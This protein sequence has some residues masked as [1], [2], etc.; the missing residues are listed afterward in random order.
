[1]DLCCVTWP[2][3]NGGLRQEIQCQSGD[4][5]CKSFGGDDG[6]DWYVVEV[7]YDTSTDQMEAYI[8][9]GKRGES[10]SI[11][12]NMDAQNNRTAIQ[13]LIKFYSC[14]IRFSELFASTAEVI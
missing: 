3:E 1:M 14:W 13:Q 9:S 8:Y 10:S 12:Q 6:W 7:D 5:K 2:A 4:L 11:N